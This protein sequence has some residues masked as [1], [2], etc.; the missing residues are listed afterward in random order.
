L[1]P[2]FFSPAL[3]RRVPAELVH[4]CRRLDV[5]PP[6][7]IFCVNIATQRMR[8]FEKAAL[9]GAHFQFPHYGFIREYV[10]STSRFGIGQEKDS[11]QTPLGL[12]R[13]AQK[14]G[15]G[16]ILG[17]VFRG[18][19]PVGLTWNGQPDARIVHRIL[20]LEG[21]EPGFN[22]GGNVDTRS[23]F[24]YIHGFGDET[25]LGRP[26]SCGC[27]HVAAS[28]L[29]PLYDRVPTGTLVWIG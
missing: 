6:R 17:T 15:A 4:A 8:L 23:R 19:R 27:I 14:I 3:T 2:P 13:I 5:L 11:N 9:G 26:A 29:I 28:D 10:I 21:L 20:W 22:R 18:R 24:V 12:H 25:T 1:Q 7:F 16:E